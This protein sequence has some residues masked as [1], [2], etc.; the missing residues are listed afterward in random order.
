VSDPR[1]GTTPAPGTDQGKAAAVGVVALPPQRA[2]LWSMLG[3]RARYR[4]LRLLVDE[5]GLDG[6]AAVAAF[7]HALRHE[8]SP[9]GP[10]VEQA[11]GRAL[12]EAYREAA[13]GIAAAVRPIAVAYV[14]QIRRMVQQLGPVMEQ[15]RP[16][17]PGRGVRGRRRAERF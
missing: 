14:E 7:E 11:I 6:A 16:R 12:G 15:S 9:W 17:P 8:L 2:I 10:D 13:A 1:P 3:G 4:A 5:H